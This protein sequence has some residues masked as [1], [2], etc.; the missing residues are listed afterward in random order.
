MLPPPTQLFLVHVRVDGSNQ[1]VEGYLFPLL[2][3]RG[4]DVPAG[5]VDAR[6]LAQAAGLERGDGAVEH[7]GVALHADLLEEADRLL[8]DLLRVCGEGPRVA[9]VQEHGELAAPGADRLFH[10]VEERAQVL[11]LKEPFEHQLVAV[12]RLLDPVHVSSPPSEKIRR[13]Q[14]SSYIKSAG[15]RTRRDRQKRGEPEGLPRRWPGRTAW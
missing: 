10:V 2:L 1:P 9:H 4:V 13:L 5:G 14:N 8:E 15:R 11:L 12:L 7:H 3:R 6:L